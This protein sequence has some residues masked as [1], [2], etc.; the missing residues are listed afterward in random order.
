MKYL[1]SN[2]L[3]DMSFVANNSTDPEERIVSKKFK[4]VYFCFCVYIREKREMKNANRTIEDGRNRR[5]I[6]LTFGHSTLTHL[7]CV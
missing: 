5:L 3:C 4:R 6:P 7:C 2:I 1:S